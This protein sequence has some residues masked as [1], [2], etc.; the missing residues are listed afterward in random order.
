MN[1]YEIN[2]LRWL[3]RGEVPDEWLKESF[4]HEFK[5]GKFYFNFKASFNPKDWKFCTG[6]VQ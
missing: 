4:D 6:S 2:Y 5:D 1:K 3:T